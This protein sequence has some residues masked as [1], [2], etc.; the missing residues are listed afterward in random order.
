MWEL[1]RARLC[2][3]TT[4]SQLLARVLRDQHGLSVEVGPALA[5]VRHAYSHF[6]VTLHPYTCRV[7]S[8]ATRAAEASEVA[9]LTPV[10]LADLPIARADRKVLTRLPGG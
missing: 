8:S 10:E 1:P 2:I 5:V 4:A 6:K 3:G 9:W 7:T